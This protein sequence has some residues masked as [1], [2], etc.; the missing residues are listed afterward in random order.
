MV[1][2]LAGVVSRLNNK[3]L[4][5]MF[6]HFSQE[7]LAAWGALCLFVWSVACW[8]SYVLLVNRMK[9]KRL[10]RLCF[11]CLLIGWPTGGIFLL[12]QTLEAFRLNVET[13][14]SIRLGYFFTLLF[15]SLIVAPWATMGMIKLFFPKQWGDFF[16]NLRSQVL[17]AEI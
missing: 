7:W 9:N 10:I 1:R 11:I 14:P 13:T 2:I 4:L 12:V 8:A 15:F 6:A 3:E 16:K 17:R 5:D